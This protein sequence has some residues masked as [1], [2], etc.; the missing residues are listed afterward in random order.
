MLDNLAQRCGAEGLDMDR[1]TFLKAAGGS[2]AMSVLPPMGNA[3]AQSTADAVSPRSAGGRLPNILWICTD[4]QRWDTIGALNNPHVHTPNIDR[5]VESGVAFNYAYCQNPICSP[6]RSSFLTGMY[7]AAVNG[8]ING[9]DQWRNS[10]PLVTKMLADGGYRCGLSGKLHLAGKMGRPE[11]RPSDGDGYA[12]FHPSHGPQEPIANEYWDWLAAQGHDY[13][14]LKRELGHIPAEL[15]Q[16][17]WCADRAIDFIRGNAGRPWLFSYNCYDPHNPFDPPPEF[18]ERYDLEKLE[19]LF[20]ES[21]LPFQRKLADMGINFQTEPE[22]PDAFDG[23]LLKAQYLAQIDQI[24]VHVGRMMAALEQ[25]GQLEDTIVIFMSDHGD[26][27]GDHGL[28]QKGCR[29]YDAAVRV[30]LIVS[31]PGRFQAGLRSDAL[32]ELIDIAPTLLEIAGIEQPHA[33]QGRS[34]HGILTG[35]ADPGEHREFVRAE[36]YGTLEGPQTYATM[37]RDRRYKHIVY[38]GHDYGELYDMEQD[39]G[40]FNSLWDDPAHADMRFAM[41]LRNFDAAAFAVDPGTPRVGR[42]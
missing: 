4:Q 25:S 40:E 38:H 33:M 9:N 28:R 20:R 15:H 14:T 1:R 3:A 19:L 41:T 8:C 30:P 6:S 31:W 2:I 22:H 16:T 42:Y 39:P 5:L 37:I 35:Q 26:M 29:F 32:V 13:R 11:Q 23:K 10:A 24:D 36:Y 18:V 12:V 34:L 21:D 7:P 27:T 17:K